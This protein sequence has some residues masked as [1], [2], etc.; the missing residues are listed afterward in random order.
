MFKTKYRIVQVGKRNL[1]YIEHRFW[2]SLLWNR[3]TLYYIHLEKAISAIEE[4]QMKDKVVWE[5]D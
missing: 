4:M 2:W 1:F 5:S 3:D